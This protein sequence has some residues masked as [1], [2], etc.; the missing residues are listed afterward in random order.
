[1]TFST[2]SCGVNKHC[3]RWGLWPPN[4]PGKAGVVLSD[5][6][7]KRFMIHLVAASVNVVAFR[8][9]TLIP[10]Q[11]RVF[12]ADTGRSGLFAQQ[13]QDYSH[14]SEIRERADDGWRRLPKATDDRGDWTATE[15]YAV[16]RCCR[17]AALAMSCVFTTSHSAQHDSSFTA[18]TLKSKRSKQWLL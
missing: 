11:A 6:R 3:V 5:L 14:R 15:A 10:V 18:V 1:M 7:K 8:P 9:I 2:Y 17:Y 4:F 13:V 12:W 16:A